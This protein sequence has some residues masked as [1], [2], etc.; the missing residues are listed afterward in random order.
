MTKEPRV[1]AL[2]DI[3]TNSITDSM[4]NDDGNKII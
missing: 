1:L 2:P 3:A 4:L